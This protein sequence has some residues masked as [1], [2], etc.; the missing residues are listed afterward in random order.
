MDPAPAAYRT[1]PSIGCCISEGSGANSAI[2]A[3]VVPV[4]LAAGAASGDPKQSLQE[5][6]ALYSTSLPSAIGRRVTLAPD[7]QDLHSANP[8]RL[9][10][11][12]GVV[13]AISAK[14]HELYAQYRFNECGT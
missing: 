12:D 11:M 4:V 2:V 1:E 14:S 13:N 9:H 3:P 10:G 8:F 7:P 5:L 6:A